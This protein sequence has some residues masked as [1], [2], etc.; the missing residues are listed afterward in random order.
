MCLGQKLTLP[1]KDTLK[2]I[3]QTVNIVD[4]FQG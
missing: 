1:L 4:F 3:I 2:H